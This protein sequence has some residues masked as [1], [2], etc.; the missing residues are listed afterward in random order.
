Y[1]LPLRGSAFRT[2]RDALLDH[3]ALRSAA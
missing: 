1:D 2:V 3:Y